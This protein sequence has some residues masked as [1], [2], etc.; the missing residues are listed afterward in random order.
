MIVE[1]FLFLSQKRYILNPKIDKFTSLKLLILLVR[2]LQCTE[3]TKFAKKQKGMFKI[4]LSLY[5]TWISTLLSDSF[6]MC[7]CF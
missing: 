5:C 2:A 1:V 3:T 4:H 6:G 7:F